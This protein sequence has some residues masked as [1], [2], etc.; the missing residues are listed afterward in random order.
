MGH[1]QGPGGH[2]HLW[3][4]SLSL[5]P[6]SRAGQ[7]HGDL[8]PISLCVGPGRGSNQPSPHRAQSQVSP[9]PSG[10]GAG[11]LCR[12]CRPPGRTVGGGRAQCV[13]CTTH[14]HPAF[15]GSLPSLL[16]ATSGFSMGQS[17]FWWEQGIQRTPGR[18]SMSHR[19]QL[20]WVLAG[21]RW[22][23]GGCCGVG[24]WCW[25]YIRKVQIL[26]LNQY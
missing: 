22:C 13:L 23:G 12:V 8:D 16:P 17:G 1:A 24:I 26:A 4:G 6:E 21:G 10:L 7:D 18:L 20:H 9:G 3:E 25:W 14:L 2:I 19:G 11:V 5:G 15:R